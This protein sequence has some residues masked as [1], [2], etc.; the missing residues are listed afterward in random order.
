[1]HLAI[2]ILLNGEDINQSHD[3]E[4][5]DLCLLPEEVD[6]TSA[7]LPSDS[8]VKCIRGRH[9]VFQCTLVVLFLLNSVESG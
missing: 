5:G 8:E 9:S 3:P 4:A 2:E 7:L 1:M 6:T